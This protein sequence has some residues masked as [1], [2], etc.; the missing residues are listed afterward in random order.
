[1]MR[2]RIA[3]ALALSVLVPLSLLAADVSGRWTAKFDT[4]LGEQNYVYEFQVKGTELT[5]TATS[6]AGPAT[7][8]KNGKSDGTTIT[9]VETLS[10]MGMEL[11]VTYT[12]KVVSDDEIQTTRDVGGFAQEQLVARRA[13]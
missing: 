7:A 11:A 13:K 9:F 12:G 1:M 4:Q 3:A 10:V 8:L 5:G 6:G 2:V